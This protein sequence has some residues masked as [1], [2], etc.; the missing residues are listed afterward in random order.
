MQCK[1]GHA[2]AAGDVWGHHVRRAG[3]HQAVRGLL[4][5]G[6]RDDAQVRA[7]RARDHCDV[8]VLG[9]RVDGA[10]QAARPVDPGFTQDLLGR[11]RPQQVRDS[12]ALHVL[13]Q[14]HLAVDHDER[15]GCGLQLARNRAAHASVRADD[16]VVVQLVDAAVHPAAP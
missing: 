9:V 12:I 10:D 6:A 13:L 2:P 14:L 1:R 16:E 11:R 4:L 5:R 7:Q 15:H 3:T 8:N